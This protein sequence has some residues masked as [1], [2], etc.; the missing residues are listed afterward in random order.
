M[1]NYSKIIAIILGLSGCVTA[2]EAGKQ[3]PSVVS[4]V[5]LAPAEPDTLVTTAN[6]RFPNGAT[7]RYVWFENGSGIGETR[8]SFFTVERG[9]PTNYEYTLCLDGISVPG[10][11]KAQSSRNIDTG[12]GAGTCI[13]SGRFT[14]TSYSSDLSRVVI[15][16]DSYSGQPPRTLIYEKS[17]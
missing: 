7:G 13:G 4:N 14:V 6:K 16:Y 17:E 12:C 8:C 2:E 5:A 11:P 9:R 10:Y 15:D 3:P 1:R